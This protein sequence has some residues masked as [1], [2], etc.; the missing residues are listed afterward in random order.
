MGCSASHKSGTSGF[1]ATIEPKFEKY[2]EKP[3]YFIVKN[4]LVCGELKVSYQ[5][6]YNSIMRWNVDEIKLALKRGL[7][8]NN[9]NFIFFVAYFSFFLKQGNIRELIKIIE[10][11]DENINYSADIKCG[12]HA[13]KHTK[14]YKAYRIDKYSKTIHVFIDD[15]LAL[16]VN[17]SKD[18]YSKCCCTYNDN[19]EWGNWYIYKHVSSTYNYEPMSIETYIIFLKRVAR[20]NIDDKGVLST[21]NWLESWIYD[22][23]EKNVC[24]TKASNV[25]NYPPIVPVAP[26]AP[27]LPSSDDKQTGTKCTSCYDRDI[28]IRYNC[29]H[30][31]NCR[32]C[33]MGL[34][35][36][37]LCRAPITNRD[38]SYVVGV[39]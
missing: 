9:S 32:E 27:E 38:T 8:L 20:D 19:H 30:T 1:S 12:P 13:L 11:S 2:K 26:T 16:P 24:T 33:S 18:Y 7:N 39:S 4:E 37:P 21:L 23:R 22:E 28:N 36:C 14:C 5:Y 29:G 35:N 10:D 15:Q 3:L 25:S 17:M 34:K 31:T 6:L